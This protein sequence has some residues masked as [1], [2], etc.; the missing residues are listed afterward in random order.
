MHN[1]TS[2]VVRFGRVAS[3]VAAMALLTATASVIPAEAAAVAGAKCTKEGAK[4]KIK[5]DSY[6]CTKNPISKSATRTWVWIGCIE[7]NTLYTDSQTRLED[8]KANLAT[9]KVK[10]DELAAG[11]PAAEAKAKEYDAKIAATQPKLDA[12]RANYNENLAKGATYQKATD[13]WNNAVKSYE[14]AIAGFKRAAAS[15]RKKADDLALQQKR[16]DVQNQTIAASEVEIKSN[17]S[18]RNKACKPGL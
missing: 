7:A 4:T 10:L 2:S 13:Q 9:A 17:L 14:R 1:P 5:G 8:L 18:T 12:A 16:L 11:L 15:L 3:V 6:V